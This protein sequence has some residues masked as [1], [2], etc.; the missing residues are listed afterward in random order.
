MAVGTRLLSIKD[1]LRKNWQ[2][3]QK[4]KKKD[5]D[6][7]EERR[8]G[9]KAAKF[10]PI[11]PGDFEPQSIIRT[12]NVL[13][14]NAESLTD[15][16]IDLIQKRIEMQRQQ[17]EIYQRK[18]RQAKISKV[19]S[20]Y[21][22]LS[23]EEIDTAL[24][25]HENDE[26]AV[27]LKFSEEGIFL[28]YLHD[29][30]KKVALKYMNA[31]KE[32]DPSVKQS[33]PTDSEEQK[34]AYV[35]L[36]KKR[37]NT[38]RKTTSAAAKQRYVG[39]LRLDDALEQLQNSTGNLEKAM[40]GWSIARIRAYRLI[41]V[42]PNAYYYRFNAP[43]ERQR[44][45]PWTKEERDL[46]FRRLKELGANGQWG[47][48]SMTIPGR[49]GYQC[50]NF[51]RHLVARGEVDDSNYYVDEKGKAHYLFSTKRDSIKEGSIPVRS[52]ARRTTGESTVYSGSSDEDPTTGGVRAVAKKIKKR[53]RRYDRDEDDYYEDPDN[54][55]DDSGTFYCSSWNTTKRT[56][57][58]FL[59]T[60]FMI[61]TNNSNR[62]ENEETKSRFENPLP[63][64]IDPIT[65]EEVI[66]PTISPFGHVMGYDTWLR[67][68]LRDAPK[69]TCPF[70]KKTLNKRDLVVL[71]H[72]N[73]EE[74]R[75][76]IVNWN[77]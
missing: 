55:E 30:R 21:E 73:I 34:N 27:I 42:N 68:L 63:G 26:D 52:R 61:E 22:I 60:N 17:Y 54:D 40:E 11:L 70:T 71:T 3:K 37:Q 62:H 47:I 10:G 2:E 48:F 8:R 67:C 7:D 5:E 14:K 39:R 44:N 35:K 28:E 20:L 49:V 77:S 46:F 31:L 12:D 65:L 23:E 32:E 6:E 57:G 4:R 75:N 43:G 41:D 53:R 76:K 13:M 58:K 38:L 50:S 74:Y 24:E 15:A 59:P 64:F 36:M 72:D 66:K 69:N 16:E 18:E 9:K 25:E 19:K 45:G 51:Y 29:L 1:V 33:R 56:R